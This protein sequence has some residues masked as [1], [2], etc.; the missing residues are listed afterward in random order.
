MDVIM[1]IIFSVGR[2]VVIRALTKDS[3]WYGGDDHVLVSI[4]ITPAEY[5][6]HQFSVMCALQCLCS[7]LMTSDQCSAQCAVV[8][9]T[10]TCM[11]ICM[12]QCK[13]TEH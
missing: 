8:V 1:I 7:V 2:R 11:H 3:K 9:S 13:L 4:R 12:Y 6:Y 5:Q 10:D